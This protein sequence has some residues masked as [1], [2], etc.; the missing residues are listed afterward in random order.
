MTAIKPTDAGIAADA[1]P[2]VDVPPPIDPGKETNLAEGSREL[3]GPTGVLARNL[4][5]FATRQEQVEMADAID[6]AIAMQQSL[7]VEAGTGVGKTFAYLVPLVQ[8]GVRAIVSTGT[9]NLQDQLFK[10]DL[11]RLLAALEQSPVIALLKGRSN[12]LCLHRFQQLRRSGQLRDPVRLG[13][14]EKV[15]G[16]LDRT[17]AG[18]V[19]E[20][21]DLSE[22]PGLLPQLTSTVDNC[23]G[24][25]CEHY[26]DCFVV[27]ARRAAQDADLV[28]VNHHLLFADLAIK[29]QGFGELLPHAQVIVVD[30][31]HQVPDVATRF[32]GETLSSRQLLDLV[33]D[34]RKEASE[35][36]AADVALVGLTAELEPAL[37]RLRLAMNRSSERGSWETLRRQPQVDDECVALSGILERLCAALEPLAPASSGLESC[38]LRSQR[39]LDQLNRLRAEDDNNYVR[40]YELSRRG[41]LV[42][43]TPLSLAEPMRELRSAVADTWIYTSATLSVS[44]RFDLFQQQLGLEEASTVSLP[45]PFD[46]QSNALLYHPADLPEP[47]SREYVECLMASVVPVLKLTAGRAFLLF[48]S[49]RNLRLAAEIL[50]RF[51]DNPL[52]VQGHGSRLQ[53]LEGFRRSGNGVLLG[54]ASFWEGVDVPGEALSCV[55]I[56]KLPFAPPDDPVLEARMKRLRDEGRD[57]FRN[58]QLP[59]AV[60]ALKQG[61]GRLIR[62][63]SDRGLVVIG[64]PR[65]TTKSYGKV[66]LRS[67]PPLPYTRDLQ[68]VE[69]FLEAT[70]ISGVES[71]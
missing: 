47:A 63:Y 35:Q 28:V 9:R 29:Q 25:E 22:H 61:V 54:A 24:S 69:E 43:R 40:W 58:Y 60:L 20:V 11:P 31:A 33:S 36:S 34:C 42:Q 14:L 41:F 12:Y 15:R 4:E 57:P 32:F 37:R 26:G 8:A 17:T 49:H 23:L 21:G 39:Q 53:L 6:E 50:P 52:F 13:L 5:G 51:M 64:D 71:L 3:L 70:G 30:E 59:A 48:T 10:R 65:L 44:G 66:F 18:E 16:W 19:A 62:D 27:K 55:V 67:L 45:S 38:W 68:R 56:D 1:D 7:V 46:Y 2:E